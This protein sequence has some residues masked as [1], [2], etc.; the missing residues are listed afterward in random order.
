MRELFVSATR[1]RT[2]IKIPLCLSPPV[3]KSLECNHGCTH[4]YDTSVFDPKYIYMGKFCPKYQ[5]RQFKLKFSTYT[6]SNIQNSMVV[7]TFSIFDWK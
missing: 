3:R 5:N 6:N 7:F 4:K 2:D 1:R